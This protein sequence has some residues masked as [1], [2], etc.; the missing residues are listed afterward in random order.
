MRFS[1]YMFD[2]DGTLIDSIDLILT[3]YRHTTE[4]HLGKIPPERQWLDGIGTP[5]RLQL[6]GLTDDTALID[7]MEATYKEHQREHHDR[8]LKVY[9]GVLKEVR[10][11]KQRGARLCVVT[12]KS[13]WTT[14]QGLRV[15][16]FD[17]FFDG[18]VTVLDVKK[19]KP[20][21][22]PVL[23]A[24]EVM[25]VKASEAVFVG[26]S[27]HD[28]TSGRRAGVKTAAV[29]WGPFDRKALEPCRPDFW[30]ERPEDLSRL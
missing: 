8:L 13:P 10:A 11:I 15:C 21:P 17:G 25:G 4:T 23:H 22:E 1:T 24:L 27:P 19:P 20:D 14:E 7:A 29:L 16:G 3:C 6:A 5:L 2:L 30:I 26:D 9:P 12:S 28:M 18:Y